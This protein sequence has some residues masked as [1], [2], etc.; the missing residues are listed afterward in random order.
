MFNL[1][2]KEEKN[3]LIKNIIRKQFER[4][5][6]INPLSI[7]LFS[8]FTAIGFAIYNY[9]TETLLVKDFAILLYFPIVI[10]I[11]FAIKA[12]WEILIFINLLAII[13]F[14]WWKGLDTLL[15]SS[16]VT[17]G[18]LIS[19]ITQ[20]TREWERALILRFGK[21]HKLKGPGLFIIM[22][23]IDTVNK[24]VDLRIRSTDFAAETTLTK[25]SVPVTVDALAFWMVWD[26]EKAILEVENYIDAVILSA[27]AALRDAIGKITLSVL[28]EKREEIGEKIRKVVDRKTNEWGITIQSVEITEIIIPTHLQDVMSKKAQAEREKESR[29]ILGE[30]E[31][32]L[33]KKLKNAA[34]IY[35]ENE[36]AIKLRELNILLEGFKAGN[37][38]FMIPSTLSDSANSLNL[39]GAEAL[40]YVKKN[41]AKKTSGSHEEQ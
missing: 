35:H 32:E 20:V 31:I 5:F 38:M 21:F 12:K 33:A 15:Y 16:I 25:D 19:P 41:E 18:S 9:Q 24:I 30:A 26:G 10:F 4:D 13:S 37:S 11:I 7:I 40:A 23:F 27:Q 34:E 29:I 14:Y 17:I 2:L 6:T 36:I 8:I 22:P 3:Y 1:K 28:L 39:A